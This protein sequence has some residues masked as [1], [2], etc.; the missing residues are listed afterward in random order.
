MQIK[1]NFDEETLKKIGRGALI[2]GSG[3]VALY[4]LRALGTMDFGDFTPMVGA[5]IP[6]LVNTIK[7]YLKGEN[8]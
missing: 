5:I 6:I 2:A 8:N 3:A 7:E 4:I 1:N